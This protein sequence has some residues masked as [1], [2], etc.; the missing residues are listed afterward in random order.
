MKGSVQLIAITFFLIITS[1]KAFT[2][3]YTQVNQLAIQKNYI[4]IDN[5]SGLNSIANSIS[6]FRNSWVDEK[7]QA[8]EIEKAKSQLVIVRDIYEDASKF[9]E[10]IIDGWHNVKVTDNFNYCSDAKALVVDNEIVKLV[11]DN[12]A[13]LALKFSVISSINNAKSTINIKLQDGGSDTAEVY[14]LFDLDKPNLTSKPLEAGFATFWSPLRNA[15]T[16]EVWFGEKY[17]GKIQNELD[18]ANCLSDG[19]LNLKLKP[20]IYT[21]KAESRGAKSWS[22]ELAVKENECI[23]Y[24]L[25]KDNKD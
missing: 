20:G 25:N 14:F 13:E 21:F 9:P 22:G 17:Q 5:N 6:S 11:I 10:K 24:E 3:V 7:K 4:H 12:Y 15:K 2:Q 23:I 18:S 1:N 8:R 19:A 16:I